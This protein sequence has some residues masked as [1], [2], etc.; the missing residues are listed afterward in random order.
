MTTHNGASQTN[1]ISEPGDHTGAPSLKAAAGAARGSCSS[2]VEVTAPA[3]ARA[4]VTF[5]DSITDGARST[6]DTNRWPTTS[7]AGSRRS[8][9]RPWRC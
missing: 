8:A 6:P 1:Y 4:V 5:G 3:N 7:R 9:A 2:R